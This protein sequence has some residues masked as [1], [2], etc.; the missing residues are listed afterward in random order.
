MRR[1]IREDVG[2]LRCQ[3]TEVLLYSLYFGNLFTES[4]D[5]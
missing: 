4:L 2:L 1:Q 3:I 5:S